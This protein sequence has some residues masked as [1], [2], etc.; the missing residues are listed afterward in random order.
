MSSTPI[1]P[2]R[3]RQLLRRLLDIYSPSGKEEGVVDY[4]FTYLK[5]HGLPVVRQEVD[6]NRENLIVSPAGSEAEAAYIGHM[7][8]VT[9]YDLEDF[10]Y[11]E[12]GGLIIG[13]GA[14]DMKGGCAAMIEAFICLQ[15]EGFK[16]IP[17]AL[18]LVV[19]EEEEGDGAA[20]LVKDFHFPW[21]V[22]GEPTG[23]SPC[24]SHYGYLETHL[25]TQG[26][27][28]HASLANRG[29]NAVEDMLRILIRLTRYLENQRE[30]V[31]YNIRDLFSSGSGYVVPDGCEAYLDL[32]LPPSAPVAEIT[33]E[34]ENLLVQERRAYEELEATLHFDTVEAGYILPEKGPL[35]EALKA[36]YQERALTWQPLAFPSHSDANQLWSAGVKP[37]IMGPGRLE[38]AHRPEESVSLAEVQTAAEIYYQTARRLISGGS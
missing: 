8:T 2:Q 36:V 22:I 17:L 37:I 34:M 15:E 11:E 10:G 19:G 18:A 16:D 27:K 35:V 28:L 12:E 21:A 5:R 33:L 29:R 20:Q 25:T 38:Q 4:L 23:L 3:L 14:A 9:A 13:L 26:R 32:H 7:D 1:K 30:E 24:L 31:V 6:E